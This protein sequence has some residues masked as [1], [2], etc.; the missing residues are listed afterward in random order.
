MRCP[1]CGGLVVYDRERVEFVCALCESAVL[2]IEWPYSPEYM[3]A[4]YTVRTSSKEKKARE[5][6]RKHST[7]NTAVA[8]SGKDSLVAAHLTIST[9]VAV[10]IVIC[11]HVAETRLPAKL[12]DELRAVADSLGARRV[13]IHDEPWDVHASLFGIINR[14]YG[15]DTIVTGLRRRENRGHNN[16][17]EHHRA[18]KLINPV[19]DWTAAEV[20]SYIYHYRLPVLTPYRHARPDA[21]LQHLV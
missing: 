3:E 11:T 16:V 14:T 21:S 20:W 19:I 18:V 17:V 9:G 2:T 12:I 6:I 1:S 8:F 13:I 5:V 15:Y 7:A 10:D 4:T